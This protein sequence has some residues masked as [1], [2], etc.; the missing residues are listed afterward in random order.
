MQISKTY[1]KTSLQIS[2]KNMWLKYSVGL[3][4]ESQRYDDS[5]KSQKY[6]DKHL[7]W[8]KLIFACCM[9]LVACLTTHP[10]QRELAN[11]ITRMM[12]L[13]EKE[14]HTFS[15]SFLPFYRPSVQ[16]Q[17]KVVHYIVNTVSASYDIM[18]LYIHCIW[19]EWYSTDAKLLNQKQQK[20]LP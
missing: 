4:W 10:Y 8:W 20:R 18:T 11:H 19:Y 16:I 3:K 6:G 7:V 1:P 14:Q 9:V 12:D 5:G 15:S 2:L 17:N 13:L